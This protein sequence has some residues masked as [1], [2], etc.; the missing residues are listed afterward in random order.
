[1]LRDLLLQKCIYFFYCTMVSPF[2]FKACST[3]GFGFVGFF[4]CMHLGSFFW[5]CDLVKSLRLLSHVCNVTGVILAMSFTVLSR[6]DC[7][8]KSGNACNATK[9]SNLHSSSS[10]IEAGLLFRLYNQTRTGENS[11]TILCSLVP[12]VLG[13]C[14]VCL[15]FWREMEF[16]GNKPST[17]CL[18]AVTLVPA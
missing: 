3:P 11:L 18:Q 2:P 8:F 7:L 10:C 12:Y 14:S 15:K 4:A 6:S 9:W 1:M 16:E 13:F 17:Y 5:C